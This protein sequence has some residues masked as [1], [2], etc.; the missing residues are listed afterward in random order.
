MQLFSHDDKATALGRAPLFRNLSRAD[1]V[2]LG[3]SAEQLVT[4]LI[5]K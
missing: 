3:I 1:L 4:P 2:E 5:K